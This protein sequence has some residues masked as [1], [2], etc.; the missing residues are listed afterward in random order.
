VL[1]TLRRVL[2]ECGTR[3]GVLDPHS[4]SP[5]DVAAAAGHS[6]VLELLTALNTAPPAVLQPAAKT[7]NSTAIALGRIARATFRS[8]SPAR[9]KVST[10]SILRS[11]SILHCD[12]CMQ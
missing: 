2:A 5:A 11:S 6:A 4:K 1:Y 10:R 3:S 7:S 9:L 12:C 8:L